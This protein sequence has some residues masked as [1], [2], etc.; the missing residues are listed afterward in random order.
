MKFKKLDDSPKVTQ[1]V[2]GKSR[3]SSGVLRSKLNSLPAELGL[4][5]IH[6]GTISLC[7]EKCKQTIGQVVTE[8]FH[9]QAQEKEEKK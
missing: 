2:K 9:V 6:E 4:V 3:T 8:S 7:P 5:S 1:P